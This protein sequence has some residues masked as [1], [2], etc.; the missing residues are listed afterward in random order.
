[1]KAIEAI[2]KMLHPKSIA[3]IGA[4][5]DVTSVGHGIAKSLLEG[6]VFRSKYCRPFP[7]KVFLINPNARSIMGKTCHG[8]ILEVKESVDLAVIAVPAKIVPR[9]VAECARK[10]VPA[11]VVISAGFA[12]AGEEGRKLQEETVKAAGGTRVLGPNCLGVLR[13]SAGL[14]ASFAPSMPP[15][16]GIAFVFQSGAL[17]DSVV[18]RAIKEEYGFSALVGLGNTADLDAADM[19]EFLSRDKETKAI[20]IYLEGLRDGRKFMS[21][22]RACR[23]PIVLLKGGKTEE[24]VRAVASHTGTMAGS[25]EVFKYA[26][27]QCGVVLADSL[28]ELFDLAKAFAQQPRGENAVAI[29]TNGGGAGVLCADYCREY[30]I[31]L[32]KLRQE[33]LKKLEASGKMHPAYSRANPLDLVG[34]ASSERYKIA[35]ETLLAEDYVK[36]LIVIQTLQTMTTPVENARIVVNAHKKHAEKPVVCAFMGG[37]FSEN[38]MLF[39]EK[40]GIPD[41]NDPKRAAKAMAALVG[42]V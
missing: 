33:T 22:A 16:G 39:L 1:M 14:N 26:M 20:A 10:K 34:D 19:V 31:N 41:F 40:N 28:E 37:K 30:G 29:V 3:L 35:V 32:V 15:T 42:V 2:E 27:R 11:A 9:V 12:E 21:A 38:G 6:G 8:S 17:A 36:A 24:G 18:D 5:R 25:F 4:S 7:G 23:K 13:P